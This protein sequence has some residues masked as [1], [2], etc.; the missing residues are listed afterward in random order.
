M[1]TTTHPTLKV[2]LL[3]ETPTI[4]TMHRRTPRLVLGRAI[5]IQQRMHSDRMPNPVEDFPSVQVPTINNHNH[6][7]VFLVLPKLQGLD[8]LLEQ[9][10]TQTRAKRLLIKPRLLG[11]RDLMQMLQ[12]QVDSLLAK[13]MSL[14]QP[15]QT[16]AEPAILEGYSV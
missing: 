11:R 16:Q 9:I 14:L 13:K 2:M 1:E 5:Q 15:H 4:T 7:Q 12:V 3:V 6:L 10:L 8:L